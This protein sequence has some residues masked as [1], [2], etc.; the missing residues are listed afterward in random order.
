MSMGTGLRAQMAGEIAKAERCLAEGLVKFRAV[1][2]R[3]GISMS[4]DHLAEIVAWRGDSDRALNLMNEA[5]DLLREIGATD[6]TAELLVRRGEVRARFE[7]V[8]G[9]RADFTLAIDLARRTGLPETRAAGR[10][11]LAELARLGGDLQSARSLAEQVLAECPIGGFTADDVRSSTYYL[12]GPRR[13]GRRQLSR[14]DG[15]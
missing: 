15:S 4:L 6:D 11:G 5:L 12:F 13:R 3:W 2:N 8:D 14:G 1:G 9:A 7:D 10:L